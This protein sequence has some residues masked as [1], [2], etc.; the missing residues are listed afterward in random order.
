MAYSGLR[1][2]EAAQLQRED[3]KEADG[4]PYFDIR[5][6]DGRLLK[7]SSSQRVVPI[8]SKL[9][10]VGILEH[11]FPPIPGYGP[12]KKP[13]RALSEK[14]TNWRRA[15]GITRPNV[16]AHSMRSTFA[17]AMDVANVSITDAAILLGHSRAI[18]FGVYSKAGPGLERLRAAVEQVVY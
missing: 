17:Q 5:A 6:G 1:I 8:H 7:T 3:V 11:P 10:E 9:I 16:S 15:C 14:F 12:D 4:V 13:G 2:N 18:S